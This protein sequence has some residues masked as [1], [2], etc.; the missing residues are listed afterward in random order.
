MRATAQQKSMPLKRELYLVSKM[1]D[2]TVD[3]VSGSGGPPDADL[4][5]KPMACRASS[6]LSMRPPIMPL[7]LS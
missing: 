7:R 1:I 3:T 5:S 2:A 4:K 6:E